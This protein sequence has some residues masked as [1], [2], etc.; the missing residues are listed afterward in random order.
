MLTNASQRLL[1]YRWYPT[2]INTADGR[3]F[4]L[5]GQDVDTNTGCAAC[6]M[7]PS[8]CNQGG[9]MMAHLLM[10]LQ[11]ISVGATCTY[12]CARCVLR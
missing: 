12:R 2:S 6:L 9:R 11:C 8:A 4:T 1:T 5:G 7:L 3:I 10:S